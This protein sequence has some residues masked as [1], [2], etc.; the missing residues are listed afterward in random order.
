[1]RSRKVEWRRGRRAVHM[2][3]MRTPYNILV[4]KLAAKNH[5]GDFGVVERITKL[6]FKETVCKCMD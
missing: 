5:L 2:K 3:E 6:E 1:M 4:K